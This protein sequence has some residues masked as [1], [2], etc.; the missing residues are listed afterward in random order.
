MDQGGWE[1]GHFLRLDDAGRSITICQH[2]LNGLAVFLKKRL[3]C[4]G[5]W[6]KSLIATRK[7]I[8]RDRMMIVKARRRRR[9]RREELTG[10]NS[11]SDEQNSQAF[12]HLQQNEASGARMI[13]DSCRD[14]DSASSIR[15]ADGLVGQRKVVALRITG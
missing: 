3:C 4:R 12:L 11:V 13:V 9:D 15:T 14:T 6:P 2:Q 8:D 10:N 1:I 5:E 7:R